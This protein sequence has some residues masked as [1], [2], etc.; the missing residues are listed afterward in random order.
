MLPVASQV[1]PGFLLSLCQWHLFLALALVPREMPA[2]SGTLVNHFG[3]PD[4][5]KPVW[6]GPLGEA[7]CGHLLK[8]SSPVAVPKTVL[9]PGLE[10]TVSSL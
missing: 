8:P 10:G 9:S 7:L 2:L 6:Q 3:R 5:Q 1:S 4:K